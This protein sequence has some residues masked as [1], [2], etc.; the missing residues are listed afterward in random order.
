M[1]C[2]VKMESEVKKEATQQPGRKSSRI[3]LKKEDKAEKGEEKSDMK[4]AQTNL[5][6]IPDS[7]IVPKV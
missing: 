1:F 4:Q 3:E 6:D 7:L 5:H 2:P